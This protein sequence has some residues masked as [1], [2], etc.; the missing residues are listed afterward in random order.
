MGALALLCHAAMLLASMP[1][2]LA[3]DQLIMPQAC[4]PH[5]QLRLA[6]GSPIGAFLQASNPL[7]AR[8]SCGTQI[9]PTMRQHRLLASVAAL[10]K[11]HDL[12]TTLTREGQ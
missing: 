8:C 3:V 1:W 12:V 9:S 6:Q 7:L 10:V 5:P 11:Q 4:F 2:L